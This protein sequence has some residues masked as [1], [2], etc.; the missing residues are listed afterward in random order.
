MKNANKKS[1][2]QLLA[3]VQA[4]LSWDPSIKAD[5]VSVQVKGGVVTL[6]GHTTTFADKWHAG[7]A[8]QRVS[9]VAS[10][11]SKIKVE[12]AKGE[13]R[14]DTE[15]ARNAEIALY[16][17]A[18]L[19]KGSVKVKVDSGMMSLSGDVVWAY[20]IDAANAAVSRLQGVTDVSN[21]LV[22]TP[23][24]CN[25][26]VQS[27]IAAALKRCAS[28]GATPVDVAVK[29]SQATLTGQVASAAERDLARRAAWSAAGVNKVVDHITIAA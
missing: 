3:D 24:S 5:D 15:V 16:W 12:L 14:D 22:L 27:D 25:D 6:G 19:P 2:A 20:Q 11:V 29:G 18:G 4:E 7:C 13:G 10:L 28:A 8:A 23:R 9:G 17:M 21:N 1:D 26:T